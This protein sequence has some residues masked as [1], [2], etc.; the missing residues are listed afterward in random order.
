MIFKYHPNS[1]KAGERY[2]KS[3]MVSEFSKALRKTNI[4]QLSYNIVMRNEGCISKINDP[5]VVVSFYWIVY[6]F[7]E[8]LKTKKISLDMSIKLTS[9]LEDPIT[10]SKIVQ[11]KSKIDLHAI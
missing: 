4:R 10:W 11:I 3:T 9:L 8:R 2:R 6:S 7:Y 1:A 5:K